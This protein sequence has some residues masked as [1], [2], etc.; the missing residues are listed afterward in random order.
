LQDEYY[1]QR[2]A[3]TRDLKKGKGIFEKESKFTGE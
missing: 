2:A 1:Q 3:S